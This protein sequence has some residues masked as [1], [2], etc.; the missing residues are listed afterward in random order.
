ML[1]DLTARLTAAGITNGLAFTHR[2][3]DET[4]HATQML[5][6]PMIPPKHFLKPLLP[7]VLLNP[8]SLTR[9]GSKFSR[10]LKAA[11]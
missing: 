9:Y 5:R 4:T 10:S 2:P 6:S 8:K 7:A 1:Q 3:T 11:A